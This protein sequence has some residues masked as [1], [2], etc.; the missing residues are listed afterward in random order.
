MS[1]FNKNKTKLNFAMYCRVGN[2][3]Q[4]MCEGLKVAVYVRNS[5]NAETLKRQLQ[6][7]TD[8]CKRNGFKI[9]TVQKEAGK[10]KRFFRF[11]LL[12]AIQNKD[13]EAIVVR[14]ISSIS[15]KI[16]MAKKIVSKIY[17]HNKFLISTECESAIT[18]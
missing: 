7:I 11:P 10:G 4:R 3:N 5:C 8:Y 9:V 16:D 6:E 17:K 18:L 14:N 12:R 2:Y 13:S 15:R 1:V